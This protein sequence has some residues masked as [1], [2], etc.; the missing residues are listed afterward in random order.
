MS[1]KSRERQ[2][3]R[4]WYDKL[5]RAA[6][7]AP[8]VIAALTFVA[9]L[10]ALHAEFVSWDDFANFVQNPNYRGLGSAQLA[11]MWTTTLLGHYVP[12]TWM[13]LGLD[14][15]LWGMNPAG[16]H[17]VNLLLHCANAVLLY[18]VARR[19]FVF[20][21]FEEEPNAQSVVLP[22]ALAALLF[23]LHPLRVESVAWITERRDLVSLL[24][25]LAS[26]LFY[27]RSAADRTRFKRWYALSLLTFACALLSKATAVTLP[28]ALLILNVYPLRRLGAEQGWWGESARRRYVELVPFGALAAAM[29]AWSIR[30]LRPGPQLPLAGKIAVSA[31]SLIFY[32]WKTLAPVNLAPLYEKPDRIDP[33]APVFIAAYVATI[34]MVAALWAVHRRWPGFA[35]AGVAFVALVFPLLG[36]VQNGPQI[37]ADR[38]TYHASPALALLIAGAFALPIGKK[39]LIAVGGTLLLVFGAATWRQCAVWQN[40]ETLWA[41]VLQVDSTSSIAHNDLGVALAEEGKAGEAIVHYQRAIHLRPTYPDAY[42]NLGFELAARGDDDDAIKAYQNA[43]AL[44]PSYAEAEINLGVALS[45]EKRFDEATSHFAAAARIVPEHAGTQYDWALALEAEGKLPDALDHLY[46]AVNLDPQFAEARAELIKVSHAM[47]HVGPE[48]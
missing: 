41:R 27:L 46:R 44:K 43:L 48:H 47:Q 35:A 6:W 45:A 9:F 3:R 10:P 16:Y 25:V 28:A 7:T 31:Y 4:P 12:L 30:A 36:V 19:V 15:L 42:N 24:F 32:V 18:F 38:Y 8:I 23:A 22:A 11:W 37:A 5:G 13:T 2:A 29:G 34:A 21:G 39:P 17:F 20:A 14:Y 40:S 33:A 1:R 26:T